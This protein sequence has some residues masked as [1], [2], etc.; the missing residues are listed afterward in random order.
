M[1]GKKSVR[2]KRYSASQYVAVCL[3]TS[4][5]VVFTLGDARGRA[6]FNP[7]GILFIAVGSLSDAMAANYEE[8]VF[9]TRLCCSASEVVLYSNALGSAWALLAELCTGEL[10]PAIQHA[11]DH[12]EAVP[13][14]SQLSTRSSMEVNTDLN[15]FEWF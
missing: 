11:L 8:K 6:N 2:Q 9:F 13:W 10:L 7:L 14:L 5:V 4:G 15:R 3:L 1:S 12:P